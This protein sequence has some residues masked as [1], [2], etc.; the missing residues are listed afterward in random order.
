MRVLLTGG[1]G[2]VGSHVLVELLTAGHAVHVLDSL[3]T[4]HAQA[5][6]LVQAL[7]GQDFGVTQ[8]DIREPAALRRLLDGFHPEAV[9]HCAG[10]KSPA[11]SLRH[12][13]LYHDVNVDG[14]ATLMAAL[15]TTSCR[16]LVF[17]SS[18]A[19]Y[20][21]LERLPV[22]ENHP[23]R[24]TTPYGA[25]KAAAET[26]LDAA[27]AADPDW[28]I[29][30]L[31]Y[32]NPVGAHPS[33][34]IGEHPVDPPDNLISGIA[35]VARGRLPMLPVFGDDFETADGTG[36]RDYLHVM[37]LARAHIDALAWTGRMPGARA[38]NLGTGTGISVR[39][40]VAGFEAAS[41]RPIPLGIVAR[42][43]G[44]VAVCYADP[45]RAGFE[46]GWV[47]RAGLAEM[48]TSTW[49]FIRE[50]PQGYV[51][52]APRAGAASDHPAR[53]SKAPLTSQ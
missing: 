9:I 33:A 40:M 21:P 36:V 5:L 39:E 28:S 2:Y 15:G 26:M 41:G 38:F 50:N 30:S 17:S 24:P 27:A 16:R 14:T 43:Q 52:E 19:V 48:C 47:A 13:E 29:A 51:P 22:D 11:E 31:R 53:V 6:E 34:R 18:A 44:D 20:G 37:D 3:I 23:L 32:F 46:L 7:T 12:P 35:A 4:G 8:A 49:A 25:S 10:L 45:G 42:R 1:A